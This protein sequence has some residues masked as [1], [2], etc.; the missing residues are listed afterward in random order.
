MKLLQLLVFLSCWVQLVVS[1]HQLGYCA[2]YGDCGKK[3]V[4]GSS[5]PCVSNIKAVEPDTESIEL[6]SAVCGPDFP[7]ESI[8]CSLD[9]LKLMQSSL[10]RVDPIISSCPACR[11]NFYDFICHFTCSPDQSTFIN[12]TKTAIAI[13]TKKEI[14]SEISQYVDP[15]YA[16]KFYDS[17]KEVKFSATNGFAMDLIGG[18]A[19]NYSQFLKFIGDEKP[20]LGG[21]PF[22]INFVYNTTEKETQ[23]GLLPR[24]GDMKACDDFEYKCACSD[25]SK[26]C[27]KLPKFKNFKNKCMVGSL[28][29]FSFS[30]LVI[31]ICLIALLGGYHVYLARSKRIS[32]SDDPSDTD[33]I[34]SPLSYVTQR[35]PI[36]SFRIYHQ[37][38]SGVLEDLF[39]KLGKFCATYPGFTIGFNLLL[40]IIFSSGIAWIQFETNPVDLWVSPKEPAYKNMQY[41]EEKFGEWY[42][43]EQ[44]IVS[45]KDDT[46]ILDWPTIKWWFER[47]NEL[48]SLNKNVSLEDICFKPLGDSCAIESFTQYFWG[49][50]NNIN[51]KNWKQQLKSCTNSPVSCLPS[52]Q[53]PLK[54]SLLFD[55]DDPLKAKA[56]T[57]TILINNNSTDEAHTKSA[58][59]YEHLIQDW[60]RSLKQENKNVN[61]DFSTEVSLTEELNKSTNT[62]F[63]IV[64]ISYVAMFI[65][66]SIALGGRLPS[67]RL[68]SLVR[69]R[70]GLALGGILII[71]I[72]V[73]SSA[74]FFSMIG[75]KSTLIIAEVIPFLILAIGI[76]NIFLLVHELH[77]VNESQ[78]ELLVEDR[79]S[80]ALRRVGPS[81][82]SSAILQFSMFILATKVD[83]PAVRNFAFYSAGAILFN[84]LI[85]MTG[86]VSLLTIDQKRLEDN[87]IDCFPWIQ[88]HSDIVNRGE[89][90][91]IN[92][93]HLI[94]SYYAPYI[95]K[96]T[97]KPKLLTLFILWLGI[98]LS[99]IPH[100]ELGLDQRIA[101]PADSY[102]VNYFNSVYNY[103]NSGPPVFYVVK[104]L[105]VTLRENQQ[106]LCGK[107]STCDEYSV[108][109]ILNQEYKRAGKSTIIEP[110]TSWI[111]DFLSWLNPNLDQC[112]RVQ[113]SNKDLFCSPHAPE[114]Q[115]DTCYADKP[116]DS[117]MSGF[118]ENDEFMKYF[119]EWIEQ[120]SDP[121]PLGGKATYGSSI[122]W[123]NNTITASYFRTSHKPL[124]S[125]HDFIVAHKNG[126]RILDEIKKFQPALD[127][128]VFSPFYVYFVQYETI[129]PLTFKLLGFA[130][131]IIWLLSIILLGSIRSATVLLVTVI[132]IMVNI[133]GV[134]S[135]WKIDLNAVS[136]VN[137]IICIGLAV[138]FTIHITRAYV[139]TPLKIF[140]ENTDTIYDNFMSASVEGKDIGI[141]QLKAFNALTSVGGSVLGGITL[142][143][144]IGISILA[145]TRSKIF[146]V[147]YFR[148][149]F[150]LVIIA[151]VHGLCLLPILLSYFGDDHKS[152]YTV[153]DDTGI[154]EV[155]YL[156]YDD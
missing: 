27:P 74:G 144:F 68:S 67:A 42:R 97:T 124:R 70:I 106:K 103:F 48:I 150:T 116:Y 92:F 5:L 121:C 12:I 117:Y 80:T 41:F 102:L 65:Y 108:A 18:G 26:S 50:I 125:Q 40:A 3:L 130:S 104:D 75:I 25:C 99:F 147:Y 141:K 8:C 137:L 6:L 156:D 52:F 79:V 61:I 140:D 90:V 17:C 4:F 9:Q 128:F 119:D 134:L 120:P 7:N 76:D 98:S 115:C 149:W 44:I 107:F 57:V 10:K 85:Q 101:L 13:D 96:P 145:F 46:S 133:G 22:Q 35:R 14:V 29:C 53:Q 15:E 39:G 83:M 88:L 78:P 1:V 81:C 135:I 54:P 154:E 69:T 55:N 84:F 155:H 62:D 123:K 56:F 73:T 131:V 19:K 58:V 82:F 105:D 136:L 86:F 111:D 87:R 63:K 28:H 32:L 113:K 118:P 31:W 34:I 148:M 110:S 37:D 47:E 89:A 100:V 126:L 11:R 66:A 51:E 153:V 143:K 152:K 16:K 59:D 146:E 64:I 142:T 91:E 151:A 43:I 36:E 33:V 139:M 30:I 132:S 129:V 138:E 45:S 109:N 93:S 24:T 127:M 122:D 71:L 95:L 21:S 77:L 94:S 72:S 38:L 2:M 114:R 23:D 60:V 112:C 20:L 49:D